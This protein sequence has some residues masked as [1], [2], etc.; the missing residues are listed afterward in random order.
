METPRTPMPLRHDAAAIPTASRHPFMAEEPLPDSGRSARQ[1]LERARAAGLH[2]LLSLPVAALTAGL[3][4]GL[5]YPMPYRD[6]AGGRELFVLVM[7]VDIVLGPIITFAIFDRRKP[8]SELRRDLAVVVTIQL[9]GLAYGLHSVAQAR[10]A[11]VALEADRL[12]VVRAID[13]EDADLRIAPEGLRRLPLTGP[14]LIATR[15]PSPAEKL[16]AIERGLQGQDLGMR[17]GFWLPPERTAAALAAAAR[18][19]TKEFLA[20]PTLSGPS[21]AEA[22]A[23]TRVPVERLG[24]LPI[25]ARRTDWTALVDRQDG[26]VAGYVHV[27]GF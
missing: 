15:Q 25:L 24:Y 17:P 14:R 20:R 21:I 18:P 9:A 26:S 10:P 4:F 13:L 23:A 19:L 11:L 22:A 12:R 3:V 2:F 8:W 5:W 6:I 16:E 7:S 1:W 27:D